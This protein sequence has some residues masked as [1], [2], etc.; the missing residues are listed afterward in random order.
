MLTHREGTNASY[1]ASRRRQDYYYPRY[2][3]NSASICDEFKLL[4]IGPPTFFVNFCVKIYMHFLKVQDW[5]P[6]AVDSNIDKQYWDTPTVYIFY[7]ALM[8]MQ[9]S[10]MADSP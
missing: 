4:Q 5:P 7:Y 9:Q 6:G 2:G 1:C 8:A 10:Y 3:S